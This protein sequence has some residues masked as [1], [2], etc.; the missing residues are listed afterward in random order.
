MRAIRRG[1]HEAPRLMAC[2]LQLAPPAPVSKPL[3]ASAGKPPSF[4]Q[5]SHRTHLP[6]KPPPDRCANRAPVGR[7]LV[8]WLQKFLTPLATRNQPSAMPR[9]K[10][11]NKLGPEARSGGGDSPVPSPAIF[12]RSYS[13]SC[14]STLGFLAVVTKKQSLITVLI[15]SAFSSH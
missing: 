13:G 12:V 6:Q 11:G 1:R 15:N 4:R 7:R 10:L 14:R 8:S 9:K 3:W 2:L 5:P